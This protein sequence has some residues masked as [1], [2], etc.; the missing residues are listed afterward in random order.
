MAINSAVENDNLPE[1]DLQGRFQTNVL[2][3]SIG[4]KIF[5]HNPCSLDCKGSIA[6][7]NKFV[8]VAEEKGFESEIKGLREILS[9]PVSWSALHGIAEIKT[10]VMKIITNTEAT[11][12]RYLVRQHG[13]VFPQEGARGLGFPYHQPRRLTFSDSLSF[14]RGLENPL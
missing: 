7:A 5:S 4:L 14:K 12:V 11:A 9:W 13:T 3:E 8:K 6:M 2:L 1:L 10:P